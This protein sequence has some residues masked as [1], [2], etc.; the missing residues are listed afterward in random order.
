MHP[1]I[2]ITCGQETSPAGVQRCYQ[3]ASYI[4]AVAQAGGI[5][6][7][8]PLTE[9]MPALEGLHARLDGLLL[10]GGGDVEPWQYGQR[11]HE[12]LGPTDPLRDRV[13]MALARW[14][15]E[16]NKP[17]LAIC[18]GIQVL[19]VALG[20]TLYQD[21][22]SLVPGALAHPHQPGNP[23]HF[24][25]HQV[26]VEQG[27]L[28][29]RILDQPEQAMAVNSMHHQAVDR[30]APGFVVSARATDGVI[31]AIEH[32]GQRLS[33]GV[34]WHPEEMAAH[35]PLMGRLFAALVS[36]CRDLG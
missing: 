23:R 25:A 29:S 3:N 31:E 34:Q 4:Q 19:N 22:A 18:R 33:L 12:K 13:E 35:Y 15:H 1:M 2:G 14:A 9:E 10:S 24:L 30:V 11:P 36:S 16:A 17:T 8:I 28:L 26:S 21:I 5:P 32:P 7:L 27:T 6:V 20:G